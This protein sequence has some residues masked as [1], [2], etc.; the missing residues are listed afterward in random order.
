MG[1]CDN[2][3]KIQKEMREELIANARKVGLDEIDQARK[4][5][6]KIS[7]ENN[8]VVCSI[9]G[10]FMTI[11]ENLKCLITN[12]HAVNKELINKDINI[13]LYNGM[14]IIIKLNDLYHKFYEYEDVTIINVTDIR[15]IFNNVNFLNY[16]LNF[17][18]G[19]KDY[20][21]KDLYILEYQNDEMKIAIGRITEI[22]SNSFEFKHNIFTEGGG[23]G[24]PILL[25]NT[26]NIIGIHKPCCEGKNYLSANNGTFLGKICLDISNGNNKNN[27]NYINEDN[28]EFKNNNKNYNYDSFFDY[29]KINTIKGLIRIKKEDI[30]KNI[31]I[32]NSFEDNIRY[33]NLDKDEDSYKFEN[34]KEIKENIIIKINNNIIDFNYFY[35]FNSEGEYIIEYI[36]KH[37]LTK[38]NML[39]KDCKNIMSLDLSCFNTENVTNMRSMFF[40]CKSL[41]A[42]NLCNFNTKNV[43]DM[44]CMF[45]HC[46]SLRKKNI[47]TTDE[48]IFN[49]YNLWLK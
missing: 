26:L 43:T 46:P 13:K 9:T 12:N 32:I 29:N 25:S 2:K 33:Y 48:K 4:S 38:T 1:I 22:V 40:G 35:K 44:E 21:N 16:D 18:N 17:I 31:R 45:W 20:L 6:C 23:Y 5:I 34:E 42:L 39:F 27:P 14:N 28:I 49:E 10:F 47:L 7:Y 41:K 37:Y 36:I 24:S 30:N 19:Y 3:E 11:D 8:G 15:D